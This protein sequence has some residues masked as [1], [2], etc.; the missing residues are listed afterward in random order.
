MKQ[1][2]VLRCG[3]IVLRMFKSAH[4]RMSIKEEKEFNILFINN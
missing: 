2:S 1:N 4:A 3:G